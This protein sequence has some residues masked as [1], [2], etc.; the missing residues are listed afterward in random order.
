M[1][2][3]IPAVLATPAAV[4]RS[5]ATVPQ[6]TTYQQSAHLSRPLHCHLFH[7]Q[8]YCPRPYPPLPRRLSCLR[9]LSTDSTM[10]TIKA[11]HSSKTFT[12]Q[13]PL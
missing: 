8:Q 5:L 4:I 1:S 12:Q 9:S 13:G 7:A 2:N 10:H 3:L 6:S 11:S